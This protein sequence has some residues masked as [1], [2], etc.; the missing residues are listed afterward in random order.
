MAE[1]EIPPE[2]EEIYRHGEVVLKKG[3]K[4]YCP[5]CHSELPIK[6]ACHVCGKE[7]DWDRLLIEQRK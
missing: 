6:Q 2:F 3:D 4:Y 1:K 7:I 5:E